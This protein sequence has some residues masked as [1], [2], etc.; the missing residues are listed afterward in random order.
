MLLKHYIH[1]LQQNARNT[2]HVSVPPSQQ[3][4]K[5]VYFL[6]RCFIFKSAICNCN[7]ISQHFELVFDGARRLLLKS[8][9]MNSTCLARSPRADGICT[10]TT[11]I[12]W[13]VNK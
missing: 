8:L 12:N 2:Q 3:S 11:L 9:E 13:T 4:I 5:N 10:R 6:Y 7:A 1:G